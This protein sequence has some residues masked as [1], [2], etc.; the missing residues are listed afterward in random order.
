M[1]DINFIRENKTIVKK[2]LKKRGETEKG[3]EID[4]LL[5]LDSKNIVN[6]K[7]LDELRRQRN[8]I[9]EEI[10]KLRKDGGDAKEVIS[11]AKKLPGRIKKLEDKDKEFTKERREILLRIPNVLHKSVPVGKDDTGNKTVR[12]WGKKPKFTFKQKPHGEFLEEQGLAEFDRATKVAGA[13]FY[14]L[15]GDLALLDLVLQ[16]FAIDT[17]VKEGFTFILPPHMMNRKSYEGVVSLDDFENVMY[18]VEDEDLYLI[19][20]S[21]HPMAAMYSGEILDEAELPIKICGLS[22][23]YRKEI[24]SH[25]IDT[26]GIFRVHQF[27]KVEEFVFCTPEQS[28]KIH[29]EMQ[30]LT[31][32]MFK[33]LKIPYRVVNACTGDMGIVASKRYDIE[34]W[35]PREKAYK[36][37]TSCSN[38][39]GYQSVRLNIKYRKKDGTKD[40]LHTLNG[41]GI[42]TARALRAIVENFQQKDGSVKIPKVLWPYMNGIK[43]IGGKQNGK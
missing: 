31:E 42:A 11:K 30:K 10:N 8:V 27:N 28:W 36:E 40:Y 15:K 13:G 17:L 14:Y 16:R 37:L 26:R 43:K 22:P 21:E 9:S 39:T 1:L 34:G 6:K 2:D 41:T 32:K 38:C 23:C 5:Q 4:R 20:T 3:K 29:E 33:S 7:K 24:G 25:G 19:A 35:F 12:T 18:K